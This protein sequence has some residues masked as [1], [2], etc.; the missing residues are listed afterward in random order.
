MSVTTLGH[1]SVEQLSYSNPFQQ[2]IYPVWHRYEQYF[3]VDAETPMAWSQKPQVPVTEYV[4]RRG[5]PENPGEPVVG[6]YPIFSL[7]PG[8]FHYQ[9]V[10]EVAEVY[11]PDDYEPNTLKSETQVLT[12]PYPIVRTGHYAVHFIV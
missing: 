8:S 5:T 1:P 9:P 11:V 6:Q 4:F 7:I 3:A 2:R 10:V 12:Q